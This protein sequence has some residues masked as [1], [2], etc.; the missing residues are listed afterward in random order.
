MGVARKFVEREQV[1]GLAR[2]VF[3]SERHLNTVARQG[4]GSKKGVY[5]LLF[6]DESTAI[7]YVWD[8][9]ENYWPPLPGGADSDQT[10]PFA[11]ASGP[12]LF[13]ASHACLEKIGVRTPQVYLLD[14]SRSHFPA[15]IAVVEDVRGGTLEARL[16][17]NPQG[18]E[19]ILARLGEALRAMQQLRGAYIGKIALVDN[20][21]APQ[22]RTCEQVVLERALRHLT[23]AAARVERVAQVRERL[24]AQVRELA[25]VVRPRNE[26]RLIHGELGPDHVLVDERGEPV[27]IDIEG[28]MFFDVEWEH[29]FLQLRFRQHYHWLRAH[30]LDD[31]RL[32]L[33]R[34]AMHLS[35]I[36]GPL[37][38]LDGDY[39]EREEMLDIAEAHIQ[40]VFTFLHEESER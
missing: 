26:Y 7:L 1:T 14:R 4:G 11:D 31:Q 13:E 3:G 19:P 36:A 12:D 17:E 37:R 27:L 9:A 6:D 40:R 24:E 29:V 39:P 20:G 25:A 33:Y 32:Q 10:D 18:A 38:L 34:L 30:N 5:R 8:A 15:D 22:D 2:A 23:E 21:M 28:A 35:L 16:Q